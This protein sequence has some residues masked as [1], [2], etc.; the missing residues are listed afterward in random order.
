VAI[1]GHSERRDAG[2]VSLILGGA[3]SGKSR[4]AEVIVARENKSAVYVATA[5]AHDE[6]MAQRITAHRERRGPN[7]RTQEIPLDLAQ[8]LP[9]LLRTADPILVDCLTLWLSNIMGGQR[10]A[11]AEIAALI[12]GLALARGPLVLVSNETGLGIVPDNAL[13]RRFRDLSGVMNQQIAAAADNVLLVAA[14]LPLVMKGRN[15]APEPI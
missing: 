11:E 14:G 12:A 3:R 8:D 10:D 1:L 13:A 9:G 2:E 7:W 5:Q 4:L 6:E 15:P